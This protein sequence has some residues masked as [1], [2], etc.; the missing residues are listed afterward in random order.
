MKNY[1][2]LIRLGMLSIAATLVVGCKGD[3][4]PNVSINDSFADESQP[5]T[6]ENYFNRQAELGA[7]DDGL[8]YETHFTDGK[9]NSLGVSKL[10]LITA[11]GNAGMTTVYL[12]IAKDNQYGARQDSVTEFFTKKGI[13]SDTYKI[14]AGP[15]L[16]KGTPASVGISGLSKQSGDATAAGAAPVATK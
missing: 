4:K 1:S 10:N 15:N 3:H 7:R 13:S 6:V 14:V 8:L 12:D 5:R 16:G 11:G 9:L 2:T